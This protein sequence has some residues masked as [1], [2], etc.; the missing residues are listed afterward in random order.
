[1]PASSQPMPQPTPL[2]ILR[3]PNWTFSEI[4]HEAARTHSGAT[5][6]L[7]A[8]EDPIPE[9]EEYVE[10]RQH[11]VATIET[12]H[13]PLA[14]HLTTAGATYRFVSLT[15]DVPAHPLGPGS[16][17]V[18]AATRSLPN[19]GSLRSVLMRCLP[20]LGAHEIDRY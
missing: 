19:L 13:G 3:E 8:Y 4:I 7:S 17:L 20:D 12:P 11:Q 14:V 1:M 2:S 18:P 15:L 10:E 6:S 16:P 5:A 9:T